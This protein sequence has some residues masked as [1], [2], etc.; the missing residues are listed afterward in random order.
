MCKHLF[1]CWPWS[2]LKHFNCPDSRTLSHSLEV[3][4]CVWKG[5]K[6]KLRCSVTQTN[7][8]RVDVGQR[9]Q[10]TLGKRASPAASLHLPA[11]SVPSSPC[12]SVCL[13]GSFANSNFK[14]VGNLQLHFCPEWNSEQPAGINMPAR[15][16]A[17][18]AACGPCG[19][20]Y[21]PGSGLAG[22]PANPAAV[23]AFSQ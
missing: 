1:M 14:F 11:H 15:Q 18:Q 3:S 12:L 21:P 13:S 17:L 23:A 19:E 4:V 8:L 5:S 2:T 20:S 22:L 9:L 10:M 7:A 6:R 16:T